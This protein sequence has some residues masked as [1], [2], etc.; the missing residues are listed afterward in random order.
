MIHC[1]HSFHGE[2]TKVHYINSVCENFYNNIVISIHFV[3]PLCGQ[4]V[5]DC[6]GVTLLKANLVFKAQKNCPFSL[7]RGVP[8]I[9]VI[10][11][12]IMWK[13]FLEQILC[14]LNRVVPKERFHCIMKVVQSITSPK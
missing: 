7:N 3:N 1:Y 14:L 5:F 2:F 6:Q 12:K 9:E 11:T 8:S 13:F 10:D 4:S